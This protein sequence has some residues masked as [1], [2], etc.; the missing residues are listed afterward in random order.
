MKYRRPL[1]GFVLGAIAVTA[2]LGLY[3]VL[4]PDFGELQAKVLGTSAAISGAS[5]LVL[6]CTPAWERRLVWPLPAVGAGLVVVAFLLVVVGMWAEVTRDGYWKTVGTVVILAVWAVLVCLLA[7]AGLPR[8][9]GW[10]FFAAA[11]LTLALALTGIGVMWS[12][13]DSTAVGRLVGALAVLSAAFVLAVPVLHR[14]SRAELVAQEAPGGGFC[15]R[16]GAAV[17]ASADAEPA[18]CRRCGARFR[19]SF[20]D[21]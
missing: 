4:V 21:P 7:L 10:A 11:G 17:P 9:Y 16:C 19:V 1:L 18:T 8:R 5:I 12:E 20:L 6:A 15:P 13:P 14:A 2:V 3:A